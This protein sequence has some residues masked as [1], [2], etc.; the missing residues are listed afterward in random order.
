[1]TATP[2][3]ITPAEERVVRAAIKDI[4]SCLDT[5]GPPDRTCRSVRCYPTC[6]AVR[7]LE[8]ERKRRE[9]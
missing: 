1:M 9:R 5:D 3:H 7:A 6:C 4:R 8:R 2:R